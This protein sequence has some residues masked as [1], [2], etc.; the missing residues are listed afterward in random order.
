MSGAPVNK[1]SYL[2]SSG[3][4]PAG[5]A[6]RIGAAI[7]FFRTATELSIGNR[8]LFLDYFN[9]LLI[10]LLSLIVSTSFVLPSTVF[11]ILLT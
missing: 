3:K 6:L 2:R 11:I 5:A 9:T 10:I 4:A 8:Y 1:Q 7:L